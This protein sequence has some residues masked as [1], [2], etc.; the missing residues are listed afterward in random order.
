MLES[1]TGVC[2][3]MCVCECVRMC[4]C[5]VDAVV[6]SMTVHRF[7]QQRAQVCETTGERRC[8]EHTSGLTQLASSELCDLCDLHLS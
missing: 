6:F 5:E 2:V 3:R 8:V 7:H 1:V 4:V